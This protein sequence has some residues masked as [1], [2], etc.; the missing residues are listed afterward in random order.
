MRGIDVRDG[1]M[2]NYAQA[3]LRPRTERNFG[4]YEISAARPPHDCR[5]T[6]TRAAPGLR[7]RS[8]R[9]RARARRPPTT[10][11]ARRP[12]IANVTATA[13]QTP[14]DRLAACAYCRRLL[15]RA[16]ALQKITF[17]LYD[18]SSPSVRRPPTR[19]RW[20]P[21]AAA[22]HRLRGNQPRDQPIATR[23]REGGRGRE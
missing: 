9:A 1:F 17:H 6:A 8:P 5:A 12:A 7:P 10:V 13:A 19:W 21:A 20:T 14:H 4:S 16:R 22:R 18:C 23:P 3:L 11:C 2:M 15:G